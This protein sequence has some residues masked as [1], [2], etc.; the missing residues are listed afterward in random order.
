MR[1]HAHTSGKGEGS[2]P[3]KRIKIHSNYSS[4]YVC[5][6]KINLIVLD[7]VSIFSIDIS[8]YHI[9]RGFFPPPWHPEKRL[10]LL[11]FNYSSTYLCMFAINIGSDGYRNIDF[12]DTWYIWYIKC[13]LPFIPWHLPMFYSML[14]TWYQISESYR[15]FF[16]RSLSYRTRLSFDKHTA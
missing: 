1:T 16:C 2:G 3:E 6:S 10:L 9:K 15:L 4:T 14:Y 13:V 5:V 11:Q 12:S 8:Q 7:I